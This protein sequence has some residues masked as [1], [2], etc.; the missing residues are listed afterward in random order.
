MRSLKLGT[1]L[2]AGT[3]L[4][5]AFGGCATVPCYDEVVIYEPVPVPVPYP[6]PHRPAPL[7][8]IVQSPAVARPAPIDHHQDAPDPPGRV[9]ETQVSRQGS[10]TPAPAASRTKQDRDER[11]PIQSTPSERDDAHG[12]A[13]RTR[14]R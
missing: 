7:P 4:A 8:I 10:S 13:T 12:G 1:L 5:F 14:T 3:T 9:R 6:V 2:L 11:R